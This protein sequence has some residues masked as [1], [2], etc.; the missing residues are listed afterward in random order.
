MFLIMFNLP[1][2]DMYLPIVSTNIKINFLINNYN[3]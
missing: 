2:L 3:Y 1:I